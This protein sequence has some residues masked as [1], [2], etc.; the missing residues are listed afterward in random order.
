MAYTPQGVHAC[1]ISSSG[2]HMTRAHTNFCPLCRSAQAK[3]ERRV[4]EPTVAYGVF[5][6]PA[7]SSESCHVFAPTTTA[8][9]A[10][11][12]AAGSSV[13]GQILSTPIVVCRQAHQAAQGRRMSASLRRPSSPASGETLQLQPLFHGATSGSSALEVTSSHTARAL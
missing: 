2:G 12:A 6:L 11:V 10:S 13:K 7:S 5:T 8:A 4:A 9:R 1:A 3:P